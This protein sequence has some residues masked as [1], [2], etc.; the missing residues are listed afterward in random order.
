M[1]LVLQP[2]DHAFGGMQHYVR[3]QSNKNPGQLTTKPLP[4]DNFYF[5][6]PDPPDL[7]IHSARWGRGRK[8]KATKQPKYLGRC[9]VHRIK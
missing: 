4:L 7:Q 1:H 8:R 6:V 9:R 3:P 5:Q 2:N